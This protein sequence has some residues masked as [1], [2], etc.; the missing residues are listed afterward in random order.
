[1]FYLSEGIEAAYVIVD[2]HLE[3]TG[4]AS[5]E[6][7]LTEV[8]GLPALTYIQ[9]ASLLDARMEGP[10]A[11]P[12]RVM[13]ETPLTVVRQSLS[14]AAQGILAGLVPETIVTEFAT[15]YEASGFRN[16]ADEIEEIMRDDPD[17]IS[18]VLWE[19]LGDT[20]LHA[21]MDSLRAELGGADGP[22]D[23]QLG[24]P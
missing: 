20:S 18:R 15:R 19:A 9:V 11:A 3:R 24:E 23:N 8:T 4:V 17:P 13:S 10:D 5:T 16:A 2:Q 21:D 1:M 22:A 6:D 14:V 12:L 7:V